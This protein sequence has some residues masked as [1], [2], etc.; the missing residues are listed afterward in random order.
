LRIACVTHAYPRRDGDVA[1]AFIERLVLALARRGHV[2][3]VIAPADEGR[4]GVERYQGIEV[5]RVR[6]APAAW[7]TLAYRGT[8]VEGAG[9][10][11]GALAAAGL[12]LCLARALHALE[13]VAPFDVVHAHWWIPGGVAA[14]LSTALHWHRYVVTL[15]G[16]DVALLG[17][18]MLGGVARGLAGSVLAHADRVTAVSSFLARRAGELAHVPADRIAV[19]PMPV[20]VERFSRVSRG[21]GGIVTVGRLTTQKRI[22][23]I[24]EAVARLKADG[25]PMS[26]KIIGDG[27][28]RSDLE[29]QVAQ[30]GV[31]E[32]VAFVGQVAPE[33]LPDAMGD[34]DVFAFTAVGEG[35]GL[36]AAEA[37]MLGVPV[38]AME[39]GGGVLDLVPRTGAGR[40]VP[41]GDVAAL[42]E[43]IAELAKG[44]EARQMA[45]EAGAGLKSRL[46][47]DQVAARFEELY[48]ARS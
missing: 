38:V 28:V 13:R 32:L 36:A 18:R 40:I 10:P 30:L 29:R 24:L 4:G 14:W 1:G 44:G 39:D 5:R 8:M 11:R 3:R 25:R 27:P 26:L 43:A 48:R 17:R 42:A 7:E 9:S 15:H 37:L 35:L 20:D 31:P 34:A 23:L 21:G 12:I 45:A 16:T 22:G 19:H 2:V 46:A 41:G 6:Y 47:P 33:R